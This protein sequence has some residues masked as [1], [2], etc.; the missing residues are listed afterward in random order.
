MF[1]GILYFVLDQ[2]DERRLSVSM[3]FSRKSPPINDLRIN[4]AR[5]QRLR[6]L[7]IPRKK[8]HE[9]RKAQI[10]RIEE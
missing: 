10:A 7:G 9:K 4:P 2:D 8:N 1:W 6:F 5:K 3:L